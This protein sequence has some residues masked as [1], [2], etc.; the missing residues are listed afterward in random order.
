MSS[1]AGDAPW[2]TGGATMS[3]LF[4]HVTGARRHSLMHAKYIVHMHEGQ[5]FQSL[6]CESKG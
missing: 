1:C 2:V 5:G 6:L 3:K 4:T